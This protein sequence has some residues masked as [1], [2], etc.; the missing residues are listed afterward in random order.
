MNMMMS[1]IPANTDDG[2][3]LRLW[4]HG[5]PT[6]TQAGYRADAARFLAFVAK[7]IRATTLADVQGYMDTLGAL[8]PATQAR[9]INVVKSLFA[10]A[11]RVGYCPFDV[12]RAVKAPAVKDTLAER[13]MGVP[14]VVKMLAMEDNP[15]NH[16][17]LT[18]LYAA[19]LR[20]SEACGLRWR[21]L[22]PRDPAQ[23]AP[24]GLVTI[25][26]KGSKTRHVLL[27]QSVWDE[28]LALRGDDAEDQ[29]V[30][31]SRMRGRSI[32]SPQAWRIVKAAALRA[33]L[34]KAISPH[35]LRHAAASHA[36]QRGASL[37]L[38]QQSL[39][40]TNLSTT[41]RYTHINP[42]DSIA[43]YLPV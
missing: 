16:A 18:L 30:F 28:L 19:G 8:A 31:P 6:G 26:G 27:P 10:F 7:P 15:R 40:H 32:S 43:N 11:Y 17:L 5:R 41:G 4:L 37:P 39:G 9:R 42:T 36:I 1:I 2:A 33:G 34:P 14:A 13:I 35:F 21:D 25:F 20:V 3:L 38:V 23:G 29:P 12:T 22:Q 24:G